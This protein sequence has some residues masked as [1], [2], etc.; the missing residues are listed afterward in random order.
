M[1]VSQLLR[2]VTG[3]YSLRDWETCTRVILLRGEGVE[4]FI[5]QLLLFWVKGCWGMWA[6]AE[7]LHEQSAFF[8][9]KRKLLGQRD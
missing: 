1:K 5:H 3:N 8:N 2:W 6:G 4:V 9:L 7:S